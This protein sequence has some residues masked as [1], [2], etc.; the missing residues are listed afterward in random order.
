[1]T[2]SVIGFERSSSA[3]SLQ[4]ASQRSI[5]REGA[6]AVRGPAETRAVI[7]HTSTPAAKSF[8]AALTAVDVPRSASDRDRLDLDELTGIAERRDAEQRARRPCGMET[9][10]D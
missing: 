8:S 1:M 9:C 6:S 7:G 4:A 2:A 3:S 10:F 5:Q